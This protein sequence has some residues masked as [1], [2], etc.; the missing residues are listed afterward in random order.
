MNGSRQI[1]Q[2]RE[3]IILDGRIATYAV[4]KAGRYYYHL[5]Q[6]L[7]RQLISRTA[8]LSVVHRLARD[9]V[10]GVISMDRL[11]RFFLGQYI[12]RGAITFTTGPA[13]N[14][15]RPSPALA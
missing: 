2:L 15:R 12:R 11:L 5:P 7:G 3:Q 13:S 10:I 9:R 6:E 14:T 4:A 1:T 8:E